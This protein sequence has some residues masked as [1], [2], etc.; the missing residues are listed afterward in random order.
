VR[1]LVT[2]GI[3]IYRRLS[4]L[5]HAL[6][7]VLAQ[8]YENV[9]LVVS[10]NGQNGEA[11]TEIIGAHYP[12]PYA[13][14]RHP[15]TVCVASNFNTL[16]GLATGK[17][18]VPLCDDDEITPRFVP[19]LVSLLEAHPTAALGIPRHEQMDGERRVF[20]RSTAP[21]PEVMRGEEF[22]RRWCL[23]ELDLRSS[24]ITEMLRTEE[25]RQ[26]GG[27]AEFPLG[28]HADDALWVRLSLGRDVVLAQEGAFRWRIEANSTGHGAPHHHLADAIRLYHR[29]LDTDPFVQD[30]ARKNPAGW[31]E[32][33]QALRRHSTK[34]YFYTWLQIYRARMTHGEWVRAG[35]AMP[36]VSFYYYHLAKQLLFR[37]P[38]AAARRAARAV[39]RRSPVP[40]S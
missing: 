15:A 26:A 6:R 23:S 14:H 13:L 40:S 12:R 2:I 28:V 8:E 33:R 19:E 36:F 17:Y 32:L 10:D 18:F 11:L 27:Y 38:K 31:K 4:T 5:P 34:F 3:P 35:F 25:F 7:S 39:L 16:L 9:E 37:E 30:Y 1:P 24:T 21:R 29:W 20:W 22:L